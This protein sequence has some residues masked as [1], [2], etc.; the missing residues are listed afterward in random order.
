MK[1]DSCG[2]EFPPD[3]AVVETR[4]EATGPANVMGQP[5]QMVRSTLCDRCA[6]SRA[7]AGGMIMGCGVI[8]GALVALAI[9]A[10]ILHYFTH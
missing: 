6:A 10:S 3:E 9:V 4:N 2:H 8:L 5:T 7:Q 1:C